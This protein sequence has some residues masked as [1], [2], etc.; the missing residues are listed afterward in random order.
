MYVLIYTHNS[1]LRWLAAYQSCDKYGSSQ[2]YVKGH[3]FKIS[4][5]R[6]ENINLN[7]T[8]CF[9]DN[10]SYKCYTSINVRAWFE[11]EILFTISYL[12][13]V[14]LQFILN[15][16]INWYIYSTLRKGLIYSF[17]SILREGAVAWFYCNMYKKD[18][19]VPQTLHQTVID[20]HGSENVL[21][22]YFTCDVQSSY[23]FLSPV[24]FY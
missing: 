24:I 6:V 4:F 7:N 17:L 2:D 10:H 16:K 9:L 22:I 5:K 18:S 23:K 13:C 12:I 20:N 21:Y 1:G 14:G 8:T 15:T 11:I 19:R 3:I